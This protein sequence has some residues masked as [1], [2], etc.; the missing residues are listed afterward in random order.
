MAGYTQSYV[1]DF[2]GSSLPSGWY[3]YSGQPGGD[4]GALFGSTHTV[5]GGGLL[6]LQTY[7]DPAGSTQWVTGGVCDCGSGQTYGAWFVRSRVTSAGA[8]AVELLWPDA[9]VWPPEVDFNENNGSA[10]GTTSTLHFGASNSEDHRSMA[11]DMTAWHTWGVVW[12]PSSITYTVDG[13]VWATITNA[14][15]IP[16]ISMHLSLQEQTFCASNWACPS[17]PQ[18]LNVDWVAQYTAN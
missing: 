16:T 3:S 5:V 15:E 8:T 10:S 14:A 17:A 7:E 2:N 9:N 1:N 18:Q 13:R 12:T 11:I 4:P 6:Q